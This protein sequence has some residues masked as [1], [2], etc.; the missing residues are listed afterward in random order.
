MK[1]VILLW[2]AVLVC[3]V[4]VYADDSPWQVEAEIPGWIGRID[5]SLAVNNMVSFR[6]W[7][8][9]GTIWAAPSKEVKSFRL[10]LNGTELRTSGMTGGNIYAVSIADAAR[11]GTNT[12][13]VSS[14]TPQGGTVKVMIPYPEV[15]PGPLSESGINPKALALISDIIASDVAN[16]F[17][18]AQLAI[19]RHGRL[20]HESSWGR[21]NSLDPRSPLVDS[22]TMYDLA[23]VT[24]MFALNY[25]VQ[26][27]FTEGKLDIDTPVHKI[28]GNEYLTSTLNLKYNGGV[29]ASA[30]T[31]KNWK[32]T[33]RV[34]D[35]L[36]HKAG[37]PPSIEYYN[38]S[39]D[40]Q[41]LKPNLRATNPLRSYRHETT[42]T[43]IMRTPLF[44]TP[45]TRQV[46]SDIDYMLL[47]YIVEKV[48]GKGLDEYF[49]ETFARP[50]GLTRITYNPL[51]SGYT[52]N[53]CAATE[54]HGNTYDGALDF[55]YIRRHTLQGEVHDGKAWYSMGGVSG[56]AGLFSNASD[57]AKLASIMLTG[58]YGRQKY[59]SRTVMDMFMS[60][61]TK[62]SGNWGIGWWREGEMQ[63]VHYFGTQSSSFA[64]GHQGWTGVLVIIDPERDLV[65]VYLTNKINS[66]VIKPL[67]RTKIF[68]G[69]W[70]T[71]ATLGFVSQI[72]GMGLDSDADITN[73]LRALTLDMAEGSLT[74]IP[75]GA[76]RGHP[77]V[78]NAASK[79]AVFR[80]WTNDEGTARRLEGRLK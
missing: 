46:Y 18:S 27:L 32:S 19:V 36:N 42:L 25:S 49:R 68:A 8:G 66:P 11:D 30:A 34:R 35:L 72:L 21:L 6:F 57:L 61:Q 16:G 64:V 47:C 53:D 40:V 55:P 54:L 78:R 1:R 41:S 23:S 38:A 26:K 39:Y 28:L 37:Y 79:I 76:G 77:A 31:M 43:S 10:F 60:P 63:R 59:F 4:P 67:R 17:T 65:M 74:L 44:Y 70:Y 71:S 48:T 5:D 75:K 50:L 7:H 14:I 45:R 20:V 22:Q 15:L 2:L 80:K 56:H 69:N 3:C 33:I 51:A 9:Q 24:K 13:H 58:G 62:T 73:Q 29:K 52:P 12:L